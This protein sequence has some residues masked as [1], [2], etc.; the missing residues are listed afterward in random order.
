MNLSN[1][2]DAFYKGYFYSKN[3][4]KK[5]LDYD[6]SIDSQKDILFI[7]KDL[8]FFEE[9][10]DF[11]ARKKLNIKSFNKNKIKNIEKTEIALNKGVKN[12]LGCEFKFNKDIFLA[13][14]IFNWDINICYKLIEE[15]KLLETQGE[16]FYLVTYS[17]LKNDVYDIYLHGMQSLLVDFY[18]HNDSFTGTNLLDLLEEH[19][20]KNDNPQFILSGP[21]EERVIEFLS[22]QT[23]Y[24]NS[25]II[26]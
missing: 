14:T 5:I 4:Q 23:V 26:L 9:Q 21:L 3:F 12:F 2:L 25:L 15:K 11:Y 1:R 18:K 17:I 10:I 24:Y 22:S 13:R 6:W 19:Y 16:H 20:K 7:L 8:L